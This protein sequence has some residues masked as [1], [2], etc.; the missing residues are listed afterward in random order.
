MKKAFIKKAFEERFRK[1][2]IM[3]RSPGR[4]NLIG[5]HTDYNEGFVLPAAID[6]NMYFAMATNSSENINLHASDLDETYS[7][8]LNT[9]SKIDLQWANYILGTVAQI[10]GKGNKLGGFDCVFGS[11]IPIGAG[12]SSSAAL[13]CGTAIGLNEL[14]GLGLNRLELAEICRKAEHDYAGVKCGIMDQFAVLFGKKEKA[15]KLDCRS[16]EHEYLPFGMSDYKLVLC[17]TGIKHN[18]ADSAY[19]DRRQTC[20]QGVSFFQTFLPEIASLRDVTIEML[21][22]HKNLFDPFVYK[23][24]M[25]VVKENIR[26]DKACETLAKNNLREF[27]SLMYRSHQGLQKEY[28]VSCKELDFLV[29]QTRKDENVLGA[30]MMGGGFG[31]CSIN[32]VRASYIPGFI[33][34]MVILYEKNMHR[35]LKCHFVSITDGVAIE[36]EWE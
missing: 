26:V 25:F 23:K 13:E 31:G 27:G 12:L 5:E 9:I 8:S 18:L 19:N 33:D 2:P 16:L 30:R 28:N 7:V 17:D 29:E 32:L 36:T 6:K 35:E 3:V 11:D 15:L 22:Q 20:Q 4:V 34:K 21:Q 1:K 10:Q 14:F 24:C